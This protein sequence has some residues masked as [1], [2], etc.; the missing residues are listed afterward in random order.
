VGQQASAFLAGSLPETH[1]GRRAK[2]RIAIRKAQATGD[3]MSAIEDQ[4]DA[5]PQSTEARPREV[6]LLVHGI[7]TEAAWQS[8]VKQTLE[9]RPTRIVIPI[10]YQFFSLVQFLL[11]GWCEQRHKP[12][13][14]LHIEYRTAKSDYPDAE[15]SV[16]A[17]SFGTYAIGTLLT[18]HSDIRLKKLVLSGA[19]LPQEFP[20]SNVKRQVGSPILNECGNRD[21]WPVLAQALSW[22]Y[23]ASGVYGFGQVGVLN[24]FHD[25]G[26]SDYLKAEFAREFW[27]PWF[28]H[29]S[30]PSGV[31]AKA[32]RYYWS[33]LGS[34]WLW[35]PIIVSL[36]VLVWL[37]MAAVQWVQSPSTYSGVTLNELVQHYVDSR[38]DGRLSQFREETDYQTVVAFA[39]V[40]ESR[41]PNAMVVVSDD[42]PQYRILAVFSEGEFRESI[43]VGSI[44][45]F[46]GTVDS[47]AALT[48]LPIV[49][50]DCSGLR[51]VIS[52]AAVQVD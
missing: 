32:K 36:L 50:V 22:G 14:R 15:I 43:S 18:T 12:I 38:K 16:I 52:A 26:H 42:A 35:L 21:I 17:H 9:R 33:W 47:D 31:S 39:K 20:W 28:D 25:V 34:K 19:V 27:L 48:N 24:R 7:R 37:V 2:A 44:V 8:V 5:L 13:D 46:S 30:I 49:L 23:G 29:D 40:V 51:R 41:P 45:E 1:C 11:P 3:A 4:A 6:V 10:G